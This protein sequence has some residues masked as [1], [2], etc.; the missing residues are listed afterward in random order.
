MAPIFR[1]S[2]AATQLAMPRILFAMLRIGAAAS[3]QL[4]M[5]PI[6]R[7]SSAA[8]QLA[9]AHI[10]LA[11]LRIGAAAGHRAHAVQHTSWCT[12]SSQLS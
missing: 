7:T 1:T 8:T 6:S 10:L 2:S 3:Y 5:A 12:S 11:M 4:A 9:I